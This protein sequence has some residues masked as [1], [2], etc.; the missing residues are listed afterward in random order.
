MNPW[1]QIAEFKMDE[2]NALKEYRK[3]HMPTKQNMI[4][5][6]KNAF[7]EQVF[8]IIFDVNHYPL[9][10]CAQFNNFHNIIM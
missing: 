1:N 3:K 2:T 7:A 10:K 4:D 6:F 9:L 5:L 8:Y